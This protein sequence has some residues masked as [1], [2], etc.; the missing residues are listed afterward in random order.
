MGH[1]AQAFFLGFAYG[2]VHR[3]IVE[4]AILHEPLG[5]AA[6]GHATGASRRC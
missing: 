4:Q 3:H 6:Q 5:E 1:E 2:V